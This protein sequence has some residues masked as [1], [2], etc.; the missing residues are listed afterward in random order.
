MVFTSLD[1]DA[2]CASSQLMKRPV[3][4]PHCIAGPKSK[5]HFS[6]H[7]GISS[8]TIINLSR[9]GVCFC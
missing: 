8:C 5:E 7:V 3:C 1:R 9:L 2:L 4:I 6:S